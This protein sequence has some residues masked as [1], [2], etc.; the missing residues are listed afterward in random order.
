MRER[1]FAFVNPFHNSLRMRKSIKKTRKPGPN[2]KNLCDLMRAKLPRKKLPT[3]KLHRESASE[4]WLSIAAM[5]EIMA[6][7]IA[8]II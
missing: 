8:G 4:L 1:V 2:I 3:S 6:V 5:A 7:V